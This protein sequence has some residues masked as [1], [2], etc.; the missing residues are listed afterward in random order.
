MRT[1]KMRTIS[2]FAA[3][4]SVITVIPTSEA[5]AVTPPVTCRGSAL[6]V[7]SGPEPVVAGSSATCPI[8]TQQAGVARLFH[9][10]PEVGDV[11][12]GGVEVSDAFAMAGQAIGG[13]QA[14][15]FAGNTR[16][17]VSELTIHAPDLTRAGVYSYIYAEG[18]TSFAGADCGA[19]APF[20]GKSFID[21][22]VIDHQ[23]VEAIGDDPDTRTIPGVGV[24][25]LNYENTTATSTTRRA[26]WL[27]TNTGQDFIIGESVATC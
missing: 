19:A 14:S 5:L 1:P 22:L 4:T 25:H 7:A 16:S 18:V 6:R 13:G 17:G 12:G 3:L 26:V 9:N 20:W 11:G 15:R 8:S 24:L 21:S 23:A 27:Q 10:V 2:I